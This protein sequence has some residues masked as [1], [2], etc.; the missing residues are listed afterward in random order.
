MLDSDLSIF[1]WL[2]TAKKISSLYKQNYLF[3]SQDK[4][5][6]N[7]NNSKSVELVKRKTKA[8]IDMLPLIILTSNADQINST[9]L[10]DEEL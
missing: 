4:V 1:N 5:V 7:E 3:G 6:E 2:E 8:M 9:V 10:S